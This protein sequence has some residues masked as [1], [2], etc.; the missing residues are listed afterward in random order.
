MAPKNAE[1]QTATPKAEAKATT[2]STSRAALAKIEAP[3][4]N[5]R[6]S[7]VDAS[8]AL[9]ALRLQEGASAGTEPR[10]REPTRPLPIEARLEDDKTH[11]SI[12][13]T[14]APSLDGGKSVASGT[15]FALDEKESIRPDDSASVQA[16]EDDDSSGPGSGEPGSRFGS[17]TGIKPFHYQF[18]EVSE[19]AGINGTNRPL[20]LARRVVANTAEEARRLSAQNPVAGPTAAII[21]DGMVSVEAV[22]PMP[23]IINRPDEKLLEAMES[24]KDRSFLLKLEQQFIQFIKDPK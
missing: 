15:T 24:P 16:V 23:A 3:A 19:R 8:R 5:S 13:S 12:S 11:L 2:P 18:H 17:D 9:A 14:K 20:P 21:A 10:H 6:Q 22:P 4:V 7:S 1:Q